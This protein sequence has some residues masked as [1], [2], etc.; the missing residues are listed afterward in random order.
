METFSVLSKEIFLTINKS[1]MHFKRMAH[2]WKEIFQVQMIK[3]I[4]YEVLEV[5]IIQEVK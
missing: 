1:W 2:T 5:Y 3:E 4:I